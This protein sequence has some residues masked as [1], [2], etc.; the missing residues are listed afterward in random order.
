MKPT[1]RLPATVLALGVVSLLTD[2][3][4]DMVWPL[5][6]ALLATLPGHPVGAV[7][8]I[9]GCAEATAALV[10]YLAGR[11]SDASRRKPWVL[12]GYGLSSLVRPL[13]AL[14]PGPLALLLVRLA[15]RVGKGLRSAPRDALLASSVAPEQRAAAF[16]LHRAMDNAGGVL[17]PLAASAL[18]WLWPGQVRR[19]LWASALP[20]AL[21]VL[22]IVLLVREPAA[23]PEPA[24]D[25]R[26]QPD[27]P[28]VTA[29]PPEGFRRY[30]LAVGL[31]SAANATDLVLLERVTAAGL[32]VAWGPLWW[33]GLALLRAA[34][35]VPGG[36]LADKLG[37]RR[38]LRWGW[39]LYAL[40]WSAFAHVRS[41]PALALCTLAYAGFYGLTEGAE[42]AVVASWVPKKKLGRAYGAFA[43]TQGLSAVA[44][45]ALFAALFDR[46]SQASAYYA[47]GVLALC[48][49]VALTLTPKEPAT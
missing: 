4:S 30:L 18:L 26:K 32:S 8:L 40:V 2:A 44:G 33:A 46:V 39:V 27:A 21:V 37:A 49:A 17:G 48:A 10:K 29:P 23:A 42:R 19:V 22:A 35:A 14:A 43:M 25:K 28:A 20:G 12:G 24:E 13:T 41:V 45:G 6:P 36:R 34:F 5:L 9:E 3:A 7:A 15:D 11:A 47:G 38:V 1:P 31:F 16:G